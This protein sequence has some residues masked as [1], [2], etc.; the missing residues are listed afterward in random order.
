MR[1]QT[2]LFCLTF[3]H[4]STAFGDTLPN[5]MVHNGENEVALT[6]RNETGRP[7]NKLTITAD[8]G[9][10]PA[11]LKIQRTSVPVSAKKEAYKVTF[12]LTVVDALEDTH[13]ELTLLLAD[14]LGRTWQAQVGVRVG[15]AFP[16]ED[17]LLPN[18][19]NPFNPSTTI[20]YHLTGTQERPTTLVIYNVLGQQ[21]RK[22]VDESKVGGVYRVLWNGTDNTG[23]AVGSGVYIYQIVSGA[24]KQTR[25]MLL[26]K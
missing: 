1:L 12:P 19:P 15:S 4:A 13:T 25:R 11:W 20:H 10:L 18:T 2:L 9:T 23:R 7:V 8:E 26:L 16:T 5:L 3:L 6:I 22:L 14:N 24:F 17:A 21:V